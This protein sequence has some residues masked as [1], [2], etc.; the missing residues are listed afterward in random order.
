MQTC[1]FCQGAAEPLLG[2]YYGLAMTAAA[3]ISE[4][5][6]ASED[7]MV[8]VMKALSRFKMSHP[9][10]GE[11]VTLYPGKA[12][13]VVHPGCHADWAHDR[14]EERAIQRAEETGAEWGEPDD[15]DVEVGFGQVLPPNGMDTVEPDDA[16]LAADLREEFLN[17]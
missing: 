3:A 15:P 8:P 9:T 7:L 2:H 14:Q 6:S 12:P 16:D 1:V 13:V 10:F 17:D 5:D 11:T 4:F